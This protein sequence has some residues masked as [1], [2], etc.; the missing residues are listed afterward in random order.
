M[1]DRSEIVIESKNGNTLHNMLLTHSEGANSVAVLFPG[2]NNSTDLP[3]LHYARKASLLSGCDVLSLEYGYKIGV[4]TL[5]QPEVI[6]AVIDECYKAVNECLEKNYKNI[7]FISKSI[8]HTVSFRLDDMLKDKVIKHICYT[9]INSHVP[10]IITRDCIVFT[11][12]KDKWFSKQ[13]VNELMK[14]PNIEIIQVENAAHSLEIDDDYR[15]SIRILENITDKCA[16]YI[17][18]NIG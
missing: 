3:T 9:P 13:D 18:K 16:A 6:K 2:G 5:R 7:F 4:S 10:D 1:I 14:Y 15:E 17:L 8:G 12:T 11:G